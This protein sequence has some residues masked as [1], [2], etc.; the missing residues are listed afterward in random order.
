MNSKTIIQAVSVIVLLLIIGGLVWAFQKNETV[1]PQGE[2]TATSTPTGS[3]LPYG[4]VTLSIG[5][6]ASFE[7][8]SL[9]PLSIEEDSRCPKD[10]QCIQAGTV[11]VK[12]EIVSSTGT[13]TEIIGL[14]KSVTTATEI[15]LFS[16]VLPAPVSTVTLAPK[17]Y[18]LTFTVTK[19]ATALGKCY[20]GGCSAQICSDQP[21]VASTCEFRPEYACYQSAKCERQQN[22]QCGWTDTA[23]LRACLLNPPSI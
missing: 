15:V 6:R 7:G 12:V 4:A 8:S 3:V 19:R 11:R 1:P 18:Q 9:R 17:D 14:G 5:E 23:T 2:P 13:S 21:G 22:G 10:V 16:A 20:V